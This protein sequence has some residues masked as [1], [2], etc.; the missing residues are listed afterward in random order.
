MGKSG[1]NIMKITS[2]TQ[3]SE[4]IKNKQPNLIFDD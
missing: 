4:L 2:I 3:L 1:K